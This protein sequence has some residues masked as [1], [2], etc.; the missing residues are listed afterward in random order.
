MRICVVGAGAM[1]GFLGVKLATSGQDV[2]F[3]DTG[4]QLMAIQNKGLKLIM[5]DGTEHIAKEA[6]ATDSFEEAGP[7]DVVI[8]A[9]KAHDIQDVAE[10]MPALYGPKTC[11]VTI[12]NGIPW[13]YF[14][15]HGGRFDGLRLETLDPAGVIEANIPAERVVGCIA[16]PAAAVI[17]PGVVRQVE[18]IRF[19][20]GELDGSASE[21]CQ[22]LV[23]ILLDAGFKSYIL[24]NIRSE[25]WLKAW[26]N[27]SFNPIS[28]LTHATLVD[29]CRFPETR[30]LAAGMMEEAQEVAGKLGVQF[31]HTIERRIAG[32]EGVGAH[33]TSMLQDLEAGRALEV[34]ALIGS[35]V[36]LARLTD[37]PVPAIEAIYACI[38]LLDRTCTKNDAKVALIPLND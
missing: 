38:K 27:L 9:L 11:V 25:T 14:Q 24:D 5:E 21:R 30:N 20:V 18:G 8:L 6:V 22:E 26:G 4:E 28:A 17:A 12:Q 19:P 13:W 36:E 23:Q 3:I 2:T 34:E 15:K 10:Q 33:K 37:T 35:V 29:I 1:G 31:R 32:A 7:H 16:Y